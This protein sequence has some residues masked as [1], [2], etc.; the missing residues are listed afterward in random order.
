MNN[1]FSFSSGLLK[2]IA[3][4]INNKGMNPSSC[5]HYTKMYSNGKRKE[6]SRIKEIKI[7]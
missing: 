7:L 6:S 2:A 3:I 1:F 5:H 4:P